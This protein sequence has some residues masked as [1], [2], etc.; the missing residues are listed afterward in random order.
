MSALVRPLELR[1]KADWRRLWTGYLDF[2]E[3]GVDD[4]VYE[5][6][7][8][9]LIDPDLP[10]MAAFVAD[11]GGRPQGLVHYI[12]HRHCWR[13]EDVCYLQDL[14]VSANIRGG[15]VGRALIQAVYDEADRRGTPSVYWTTQ[16]FNYRGRILYDQV[17]TRTPFIKYQR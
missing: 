11:I 15:G 5:T 13:I 14:F 2:Y 12:F 17:A 3:S 16:E 8:N 4:R 1:D 7:F 10:E 6:T 9:R